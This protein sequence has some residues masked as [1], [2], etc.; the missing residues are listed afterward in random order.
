MSTTIGS[1]D[2]E[3]GARTVSIM[4]ADGQGL[5]GWKVQGLPDCRLLCMQPGD[6]ALS[7]GEPVPSVIRP[8]DS[9]DVG[10]VAHSVG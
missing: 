9:I 4:A 2:M 3:S 5:S 1:T 10:K 8:V 6:L 7:L